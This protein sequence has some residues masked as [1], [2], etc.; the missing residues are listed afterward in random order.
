MHKPA[1]GKTSEK[2]WEADHITLK[3]KGCSGAAK[4]LQALDTPVNRSKSGS[5]HKKSRH[6]K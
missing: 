5:L 3:S 6:S 4:N 1:H 2:G